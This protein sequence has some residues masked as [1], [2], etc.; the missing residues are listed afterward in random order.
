MKTTILFII[1]NL[2]AVSAL[3]AQGN[4]DEGMRWYNQRAAGSQGVNAAS[5]PISKA[6]FYFEKALAEKDHELE[7]GIYLMRSYIFKGRFV[8]E[9]NAE[10]RDIFEKAKNIGAAFVVKYPTNKEVRFENLTGFGLWG[11]RLGIFKAAKEGIADKVKE[12][13]ETLIKLDPEF[14]NAIGERA[15]A[16]LNL[17]APKIPFIMSWPD[18]ELGLQMTKDVVTR[19]PNDIGNNYFH[20][21]ALVENGKDKEAIPFLK[22]ALAMQ[23]EAEYL[24]EDRDFHRKANIML[25][26]LKD[27]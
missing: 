6:I 24:L 10:K 5:E 15:L 26:K 22:K 21:E 2:L 1:A 17:M 3:L 19:Y 27:S 25:A 8:L 11:E 23:P 20:A 12:E 18:D 14:R 9:D 16:V 7:S 13:I 4:F